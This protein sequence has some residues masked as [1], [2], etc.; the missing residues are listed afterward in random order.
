MGALKE[1]QQGPKT[2]T[3]RVYFNGKTNV[4]ASVVNRVRIK[5]RVTR[6]KKT[7]AEFDN[8]QTARLYADSLELNG[9]GPELNWDWEKSIEDL[10]K[11]DLAEPFLDSLDFR[12]LAALEIKRMQDSKVKSLPRMNLVKTIAERVQSFAGN[13]PPTEKQFLGWLDTALEAALTGSNRPLN[14]KSAVRNRGRVFLKTLMTTAN[15]PFAFQ[16]WAFLRKYDQAIL[17]KRKKVLLDHAN[18]KP[19][20]P[21]SKT[22]ID[23]LLSEADSFAQV[24]HTVCYLATGLR[25]KELENVSEKDLLTNGTLNLTA[26]QTKTRRYHKGHERK[27][28][29]SS[30][31]LASLLW[32]QRTGE[33]LAGF[34]EQNRARPTMC[35]HL[36]LCGWSEVEIIARSG[37]TTTDMLTKHYIR[38]T[39]TDF[40]LGQDVVAYYGVAPVVINGVS[41]NEN[42]YENFLL[43]RTLTHSKRLGAYEEFRDCLMEVLAAK[44]KAA[45]AVEL[46][47]GE[48]E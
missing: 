41:A 39:P 1:P 27:T 11:I 33:P 45:V 16:R 31:V 38:M 44:Q 46:E 7:F 37:H 9:K 47:S 40:V 20:K 21:W 43:H 12:L 48:F 24:L 32:S 19:R 30:T 25:S 4:Y 8:L 36:K 17:E 13:I 23:S 14:S 5:F 34:Q 3:K 29:L 22:E 15:Y 18:S 26:I 10:N 35:V 2:Y 6:N 28:E 42:A